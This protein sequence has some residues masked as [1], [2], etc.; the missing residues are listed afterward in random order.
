MIT[1]FGIIACFIT[2]IFATHLMEVN[3]NNDIE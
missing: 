1:A 3:E 2:S